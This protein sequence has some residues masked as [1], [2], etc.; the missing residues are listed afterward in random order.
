MAIVMTTHFTL[1][2]I[3]IYLF[4]HVALVV[5]CLHYVT[6]VMN[7]KKVAQYLMSVQG[8]DIWV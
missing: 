2:P 4:N 8:Y 1:L 7:F 6:I 5:C 3:Y